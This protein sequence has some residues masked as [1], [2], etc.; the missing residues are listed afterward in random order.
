VLRE[1]GVQFPTVF[2]Y[3]KPADRT[4]FE[5]NYQ[6][7]KQKLEKSVKAEELEKNK[8]VELQPTVIKETIKEQPKPLTRQKEEI[9]LPSEPK[10]PKTPQ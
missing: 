9:R 6:A 4:R 8:K 3:F 7:W 10:T 1:K 5:N 2:S